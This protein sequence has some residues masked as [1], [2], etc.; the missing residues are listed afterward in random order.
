MSAIVRRPR[1]ERNQLTRAR[2]QLDLSEPAERLEGSGPTRYVNLEPDRPPDSSSSGS[3]SGTAKHRDFSEDNEQ[4]SGCLDCDAESQ[5][6]PETQQHEQNKVEL[7]QS[8]LAIER[9]R[10]EQRRKNTTSLQ[11]VLSH[12]Q[13]DYLKLQR[14]F[15]ANLELAHN[16]NGQRAA[17]VETLQLTVA[18]KDK[19]I[20]QLRSQVDGT[21]LREEYDNSLVK[22]SALWRAEEEQLRNQLCLVEQQMASE[23][24]SH[25]QTLQQFQLRLDEQQARASKQIDSLEAK[26]LEANEQLDRLIKEPKEAQLRELRADNCRL[27]EEI[28]RLR[29]DLESSK[30]KYESVSGRVADVLAEIEQ[31]ETRN[32]TE[33]ARLEHE[34]GEQ[35][36]LANELRMKLQD[37]DEIIQ[38][39]QFN[40]QRS[41]KRVKGLLSAL[42]SKE[43]TYKELMQT[44]ELR[45]E[46]AN[47]KLSQE[48]HRLQRNSIELEA[49]LERK[50]ADLV[51]LELEQ[52]NQL[53]SLRNDRD[54]RLQKA[55]TERQKADKELKMAEMKLARELEA[56]EECCKQVEQLKREA[57]QFREESKR[58]SIELA[59]SEA[60]QYAKQ[61][62][63]EQLRLKANSGEMAANSRL[64]DEQQQSAELAEARRLVKRLES[65]CGEYKL[66]NEKLKMKLRL[67]EA[68]MSRINTA[69]NKEQA[70]MA[71]EYERKLEQITIEQAAYERNRLRYKRHGN[72]LKR[73]C[74]HLRQ[75]H[76]HFCTPSECGYQ[77]SGGRDSSP[78]K[79]TEDTSSDHNY[80]C[81]DS[82]NL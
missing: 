62:E 51:R 8:L 1:I 69:I 29:A 16:I 7:L 66:E 52:A 70:K 74:E 58:L 73:Y 76:Q 18:D 48:L 60:K 63:L 35:R 33:L 10:N 50:Q 26:L 43:S 9:D 71:H 27:S 4:P 28:D 17:Q 80:Y 41:E 5:V 81:I 34:N 21:K 45:H 64:R 19:Q 49:D 42:K 13:A 12:L 65:R 55:Q 59:K 53:E 44:I 6:I 37:G 30:V 31:I 36:K 57:Q 54:C 22:Q 61:Q 56:K 20:E 3:S 39:C 75:V 68:N 40:L 82:S 46:Q 23:R 38:V 72:K 78:V 32:N 14:S 24:V 47:E 15:V 25:S 77:I 11:T 79:E 67:S 2:N